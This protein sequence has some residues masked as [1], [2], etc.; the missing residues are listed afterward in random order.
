LT[1]AGFAPWCLLAVD[2]AAIVERDGVRPIYGL[3]KSDWSSGLVVRGICYATSETEPIAQAF[4]QIR[5][6]INFAALAAEDDARMTRDW[7]DEMQAHFD[8]LKQELADVVRSEL[9][10]TERNLGDQ[11]KRELASAQSALGELFKRELNSSERRLSAQYQTQVDVVRKEVRLA[12]EGFGGTLDAINR[13]IQ[14]LEESVATT[15]KDH[16]KAISTHSRQ[17]DELNR[18]SGH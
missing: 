2:D 16:A 5:H 1:F 12:A 11:F 9:H 14:A 3:A 8:R 17:I 18:R 13:R 15:L 6:G 10:S 4:R 7:T